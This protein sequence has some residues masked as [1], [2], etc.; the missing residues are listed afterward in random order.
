MGIGQDSL[1]DY[2]VPSLRTLKDV[3]PSSASYFGAPACVLHENLPKDFFIVAHT[4]AI[5]ALPDKEDQGG[6]PRQTSRA[7]HEWILNCLAR[8][9]SVV[10]PR[11]HLRFEHLWHTS[12]RASMQVLRVCIGRK[13]AYPHQTAIGDRAVRT[14]CY[15]VALVL[16]DSLNGADHRLDDKLQKE[17]CWSVV[18]LL[19][20][21]SKCAR[22]QQI[23]DEELQ[24]VVDA[25]LSSQDVLECYSKDL[26]VCYASNCCGSTDMSTEDPTFGSIYRR[27]GAHRTE[28]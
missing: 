8:L 15:V 22:G 23:Y 11:M 16:Q 4:L 9:W 17:I 26:Q 13:P 14:L 20:Q 25:V 12:Y 18:Q 19:A 1:F 24:P 10:I 2:Q 5:V 21:G 7:F 27:K 6:K 3:L 28:S